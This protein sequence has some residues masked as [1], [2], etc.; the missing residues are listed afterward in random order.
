IVINVQGDEPEMEPVYLDRLVERM[1]AEPDCPVGTLACPFAA[2]MDPADP[3]RVKV[4]R[5]L[6][7]RAL[8]FSR[9]V[10]PYPRSA[11]SP[12]AAPGTWLLHLGVYAY[13]R[14]FLL[15]F[16][17]WTPTP[18]ESM[19]RLEQLRI[20]EHGYTIAVEVVER[21]AA[22]IDTPKDYAAFVKRYRESALK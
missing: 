20:L 4:V 15:E 14:A 19:E 9:S 6:D 16:A 5:R 22:G 11:R 12:T 3:N 21:A 7:G 1:T 8:L 10:L 17:S 18:L 2:D 13:R